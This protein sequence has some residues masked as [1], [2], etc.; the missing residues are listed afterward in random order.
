ME[1]A[2][3]KETSANLWK[4]PEDRKRKTPKPQ[5]A[6]GTSAPVVRNAYLAGCGTESRAG[7][8]TGT[9]IAGVVAANRGSVNPNLVL[10][11]ALGMSEYRY[12]HVSGEESEQ[13]I[14][15][16]ADRLK[17]AQRP[18]LCADR[19]PT[20]KHLSAGCRDGSGLAGH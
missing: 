4:K 15:M 6:A 18:V 1:E 7:R 10:Q 20:R 11:V 14:K 13:Q 3:Q 9:G 16:R 12:C 19:D 2:V 5:I 8:R 17:F